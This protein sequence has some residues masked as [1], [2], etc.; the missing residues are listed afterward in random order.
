MRTTYTDEQL[1]ARALAGDRSS[2]RLLTERYYPLALRWCASIL[3]NRQDAEDAAQEVFI[4]AWHSLPQYQA[5]GSFAGWLR[6]LSINL[7][8]NRLDAQQRTTGRNTHLSAAELLPDTEDGPL[9]LLMQREERKR[10]AHALDQLPVQHRIALSL[11]LLDE[12]SYDEIAE[13][14]SVPVNSVRSWLHRGR[15]Q[16]KQ[17]LECEELNSK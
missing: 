6:R 8:L 15:A 5:R 7:S 2:F 1:V 16:I 4:R 17:I 11:R 14:M 3:R 12:L 13:Q 9:Q 10:L